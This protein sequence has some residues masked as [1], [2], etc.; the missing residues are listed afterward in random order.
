[1]KIKQ[2]ELF[3][4][5]T[6]RETGSLSPHIIIKMHTDENIT[7]IGEM[8]DLGHLGKMPDVEAM[9]VNLNTELTGVDVYDMPKIDEQVRKAGGIFGAGIDMAVLDIKG[10]ALDVPVHKLLGGQ[11]RKKIRVCYP[12][13]GSPDQKAA[14]ENVERVG[15]IM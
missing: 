15:R 12:I 13:F 7:G 10:K 6:P 5:R 8:S 2:I 14:E 4:I 1:M 11:Y 3:P 9:R